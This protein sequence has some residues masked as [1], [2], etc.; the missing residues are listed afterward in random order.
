[1][2]GLRTR[3]RVP[4]KATTAGRL[5]YTLLSL[6]RLMIHQTA[7]WTHEETEAHSEDLA[8]CELFSSP[9]KREGEEVEL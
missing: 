8:A 9:L 2:T 4:D 1:M 6:C 3:T 5:H 7:K